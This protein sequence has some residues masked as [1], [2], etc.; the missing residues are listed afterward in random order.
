[1]GADFQTLW[2]EIKN[3]FPNLSSFLAQRF[4]QRAV[5]DVYQNHQ[6]S[7][8]QQ[9]GVLYSP[10]IITSGAFSITQ[11]SNIVTANPTAITALNNLS[12][13]ILTKRQIRFG[14]EL[15]NIVSVDGAF[16]ANGLLTLDRPV[17]EITNATQSYQCYRCYYGPPQFGVNGSETTDFLRYNSIYNPAISSY[18]IGVQLPRDILNMRD[19]QRSSVGNNPYYL[20]AY[21]SASDGSPLFEMWPHPTSSNV[22]LCSYQRQGLTLANPTDI[23][24]VV[25]PD[26]LILEKA[27]W[28]GCLWADK[29]KGRYEELKGTNWLLM[30]QTHKK[31]YSNITSSDPGLLQITQV[32]DNEIFPQQLIV[33][34]RTFN[35]QIVGDAD[36]TG[37]YSINP[38]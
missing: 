37:F 32:Q 23:L 33:D 6:W 22:Y 17:I 13:P 27:M 2:G 21:Q 8:L 36:R 20:F 3:T 26:S 38:N 30:A 29:N 31:T 25:I 35:V 5:T 1:M 16:G 18:F 24:P 11:F 15:Y 28:Y 12:N 10:G 4:I 14:I 34:D 19:P 7:F 9:E